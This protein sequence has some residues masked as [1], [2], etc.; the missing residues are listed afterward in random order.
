MSSVRLLWSRTLESR[1][2][3]SIV[4]SALPAFIPKR[5][6]ARMTSKHPSSH[7]LR[8]T[9]AGA[10]ALGAFATG[11]LAVGGFALGAMAVGAIAFGA[12]AVGRLA[13]G[14][15]RIRRLEIDE[16]SVR[17]LLIME[18]LPASQFLA[19]ERGSQRAPEQVPPLSPSQ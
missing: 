4:H 18:E 3:A 12:I 19:G 15:A 17:R 8:K 11:A 1:R 16:L 5:R 6:L 9:G 13:V 10:R 2:I 7:E 14:R